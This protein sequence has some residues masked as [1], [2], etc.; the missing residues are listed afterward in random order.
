MK[1][2]S[3]WTAFSRVVNKFRDCKQPVSISSTH[4]GTICIESEAKQTELINHFVLLLNYDVSNSLR[5]MYDTS[6]QIQSA[7]YLDPSYQILKNV[8]KDILDQSSSQGVAQAQLT[9][10]YLPLQLVCHL[11][12]TTV[13]SNSSMFSDLSNMTQSSFSFTSTSST[14]GQKTLIDV[15]ILFWESFFCKHLVNIKL[16]F[17][18]NNSTV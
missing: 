2:K 9:R 17:S 13:S 6:S 18:F 12:S 1:F 15:L 5:F 8:L 3:F 7:T 14:L 16:T 4:S 11:Y 10:L